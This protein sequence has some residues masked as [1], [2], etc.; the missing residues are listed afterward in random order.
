MIHELKNIFSNTVKKFLEIKISGITNDSR[1]VKNNFI[2][3]AV[4]GVKDD[5]NNYVEKAKL[6]GASIIISNKIKGEGM[7][8]FGKNNYY[9]DLL[10][11]FTIDFPEKVSLNN[12]EIETLI[13]LFPGIS[14]MKGTIKF[15]REAS[16]EEINTEDNF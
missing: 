7:P 8:I 6:N 10:I 9:G 13:R 1:Q 3:V 4:K 14:S 12:I 2:F 16:I 5:G 15:H 11:Q